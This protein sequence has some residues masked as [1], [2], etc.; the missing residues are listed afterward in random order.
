MILEV[1]EVAP[2]LPAY[3][4]LALAPDHRIWATRYTVR[5]EPGL[6]DVYHAE[7]GYEGTLALGDVRPVAFLSTGLLVS[8]EHD[9][10]EVPVIV[11]YRIR[12]N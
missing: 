4:A 7:R 6:V 5:G 3:S 10:D 1:A 9:Q 8:L 11:G 2:T 12:R